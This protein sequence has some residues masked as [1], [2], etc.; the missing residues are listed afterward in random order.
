VSYPSSSSSS[1][2]Q[3]T[4][5]VAA[6]QFGEGLLGEAGLGFSHLSQIVT[7]ARV[8]LGQLFAA[9]KDRQFVY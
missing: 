9:E 7:S 6:D 2:L 1:C 5:E 3:I 4:E 8:E